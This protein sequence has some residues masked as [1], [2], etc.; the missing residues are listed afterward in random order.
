MFWGVMGGVIVGNLV[1][2]VARAPLGRLCGRS[3][4]PRSSMQKALPL[5][6]T[7]ARLS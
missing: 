2:F 1:T 4:R 5:F 6:K 3:G 7:A